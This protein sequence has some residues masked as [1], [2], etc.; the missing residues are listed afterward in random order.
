MDWRFKSQPGGIMAC[1]ISSLPLGIKKYFY[2]DGGYGMH[3]AFSHHYVCNL[4]N[5]CEKNYPSHADTADF[6]FVNIIYHS[7][8]YSDWFVHLQSRQFIALP[9]PGSAFLWNSAYAD[10]WNES[11]KK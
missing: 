8:L 2:A 4:E 9:Y 3:V 1:I 7:V 11:E 10:V 6:Y 5:R